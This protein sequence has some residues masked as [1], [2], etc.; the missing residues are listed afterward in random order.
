MGRPATVAGQ[1]VTLL[2]HEFTVPAE[3]RVGFDDRR[4]VLEGLLAQLL[5]DHGEGLALAITQPEATFELVAE[6]AVFRHQIFVAQQ[7][8]LIDGP[9]D[10]REQVFPIQRLSP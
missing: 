1:T 4:H 2:R 7:Q 6:D 3:N 8:F 9:S 5:A 10:I